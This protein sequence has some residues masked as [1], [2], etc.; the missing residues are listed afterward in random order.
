MICKVSEF[1]GNFTADQIATIR[2]YQEGLRRLWNFALGA[3]INADENWHYDKESKSYVPKCTLD[4]HRVYD[5]L[6]K[7]WVNCSPLVDSRSRWIIASCQAYPTATTKV[8]HERMG[9]KDHVFTRAE[10]KASGWFGGYGYSCPIQRD[11][12][13]GLISNS[14]MKDSKRGLG[15][16]ARARDLQDRSIITPDLLKD[17]DRQLILNV[18]Q[19]YR[20]GLLEQLGGAWDKYVKDRYS[21]ESLRRGKPKFKGMSTPVTTIRHP[22]PNAGGS[23]PQSA[24]A[25]RTVGENHLKIPGFGDVHLP[26]LDQ[27]WGKSRVKVM[28][29]VEKASGF[30]V[31]LTREE[32]PRRVRNVEPRGYAGVDWGWKEE[33]YCSVTWVKEG[34]ETRSQQISKPRF[35]RDSQENLKKAQQQLDEKLYRRLILWIHHPDTNL[36][37]YVS[38]ADVDILKTCRT[39]E[40]LCAHIGVDLNASTIQRLR[41]KQCGDSQGV[42][43]C[44]QKIKRIHE[45]TKRRRR[46][47]QYRIASYL[48]TYSSGIAVEDGL[49]KKVGKAKAK[50]KEDGS[51]FDKN[52]AAAVAGQ[53]KSNLDAAIGQQIDLIDKKTQEFGKKMQRLKP[54]SDLPLSRIC[55]QCLAYDPDMDINKPVYQCSHC[56]YEGDRDIN[57]S[58]LIAKLGREPNLQKTIKQNIKKTRKK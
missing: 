55:S 32:S 1:K 24:D 22:N 40:D 4:H 36:S 25:V 26:G 57:S 51:G 46:S 37:D 52:Q 44:K 33:N 56:G 2:E 53:N 34:G 50:A 30:F 35:Y 12:N 54:A 45:K 31:Q 10:I 48:T 39:V 20:M 11:H 14:A 3:L 42:K 17:L 28:Q 18:Q 21:K 38:K 13:P 7:T 5:R 58:E 27:R 15:I 8:G 23:K 47:H 41:W 9:D 6:S 16:L 49:Q 43:N 29:I 19:K